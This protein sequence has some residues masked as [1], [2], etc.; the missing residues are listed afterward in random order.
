MPTEEEERGGE[1]GE[2]RRK[3]GRVQGLKEEMEGGQKVEEK[4]KKEWGKRR[5]RGGG[6]GRRKGRKRRN[7]GFSLSPLFLSPTLCFLS[8][9]DP[10]S[11]FDIIPF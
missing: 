4:G 6:S 8:C 11:P 7:I 2:R 5:K 1:V 9:P 10:G 3:G